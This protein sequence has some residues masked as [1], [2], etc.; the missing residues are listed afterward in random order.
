MYLRRRKEQRTR[1]KMVKL[2]EDISDY[3][4]DTLGTWIE[5]STDKGFYLPFNDGSSDIIGYC[6]SIDDSSNIKGVP[7]NDID[8]IFFDEFLEYGAQIDDEISRFLN[9]ISTIVRKRDN[10]EIFM[11]ANTVTKFSPY[12]ELFGIDPKKLKMGEIAYMKHANGV[13]C[14]VEYCESKNIINGIKARN[15][16]IGFDNNATSNMIL[17]GEWEYEVVNTDNIDGISWKANRMLLPFYITAL[18]E[19]YELSMY[20]EKNPVAFVRKINTQNGFVKEF[21]KYNLSYDNSLQLSNVRGIV[22]T[23]GEFN[24]ILIDKRTM[25]LY[26]KFKATIN[27]K[28]VV[29]DNMAS[30]S[31]FM[32]IFKNL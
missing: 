22:P 15:K 8:T 27:A 30:G 21:V 11:I 26:N 14:A 10:V 20:Y 16:Y 25:D 9:I 3:C 7:Y 13:S 32:K 29:F 19:V 1:A 2:F 12:F 23:Y 6:T 18:G 17:Y 4:I 28:R 31:D 24:N 5:Y